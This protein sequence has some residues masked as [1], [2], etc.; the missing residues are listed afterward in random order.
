MMRTL[1]FVCG[2]LLAIMP[3]VFT[4]AGQEA[5]QQSPPVTLAATI[6]GI[7]KASRTIVLKGAGGTSV[8]VKAPPEMEGF[9]ELRVGDVVTAT[10]YDALALSVRRP[11]DPAPDPT[12]TTM[13]QRKDRM[14]GSETRSQQTFSVTI[15]AIDA[16]TP[17]ITVK[18]PQGR[19]VTMAVR[20]A[21]QLQKVK[22]GDTVDVT[23]FESLLIKVSRKR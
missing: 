12:S 13:T 10:Y 22:V 2:A 8:E 16:K 23:Y 1:G 4:H 6:E 20:D 9:G 15:Q 5:R 7:D 3:P 17:S 21:A 11:G 14:P 18:G 19:V